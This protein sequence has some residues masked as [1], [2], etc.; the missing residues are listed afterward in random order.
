MDENDVVQAVMSNPGMMDLLTA[1]NIFAFVVIAL[2]NLAL[3]TSFK[4]TMRRL[5]ESGIKV[6]NHPTV[7]VFMEMGQPV[8]GGAMAAI[9]GVFGDFS[10][11]LRI[12]IGV[13]AGFSSPAIYKYILKK[14]APT[15]VLPS[16]HPD[17][18]DAP[19]PAAEEG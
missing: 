4:R 17:R 10:L 1:E 3:M 2:A 7:K 14:Y 15:L 19:A 11:P 5:G 6:I 12:M 16:D 18:V 13:I 8:L 9:P